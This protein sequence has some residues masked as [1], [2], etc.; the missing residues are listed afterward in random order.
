MEISKPKYTKLFYFRLIDFHMSVPSFPSVYLYFCNFIYIPLSFYLIYISF[1]YLLF[2]Y[3]FVRCSLCYFL[4]LMYFL[5]FVF[6]IYS[7]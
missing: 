7:F 1:M 6:F 5:S 3:A 4:S 2:S